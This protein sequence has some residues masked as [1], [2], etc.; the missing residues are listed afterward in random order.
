MSDVPTEMVSLSLA[1]LR[2]LKVRVSTFRHQAPYLI[3]YFNLQLIVNT[4]IRLSFASSAAVYFMGLFAKS[5]K[6]YAQQCQPRRSSVLE[7]VIFAE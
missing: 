4:R 2:F 6:L 1:S 7:M 5:L 3:T